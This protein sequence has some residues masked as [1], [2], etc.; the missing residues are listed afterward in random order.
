MAISHMNYRS[1][2][3][4]RDKRVAILKEFQLKEGYD[5]GVWTFI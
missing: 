3:S 5:K 4:V 2:M 1:F